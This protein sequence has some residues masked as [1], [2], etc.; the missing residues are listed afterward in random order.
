MQLFK[1]TILDQSLTLVYV[2]GTKGW[3]GTEDSNQM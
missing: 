3:K 1:N 2:D